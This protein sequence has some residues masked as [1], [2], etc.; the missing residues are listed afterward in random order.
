[1]DR[2]RRLV[3][4]YQA[5][6]DPDVA[7]DPPSRVTYEIESMGQASRLTV[8]HDGFDTENATYHQIGEGLPIVISGLKTL[9]ETGQP[10]PTANTQEP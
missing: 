1:M 4:S 5:R 7:Q 10:L 6:W 3:T 2:P 8:T 9:L